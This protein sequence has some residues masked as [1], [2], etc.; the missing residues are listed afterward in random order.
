MINFV[1]GIVP[2]IIM[3][4]FS[5]M[6]AIYSKSPALILITLGVV[7]LMLYDFIDTIRTDKNNNAGSGR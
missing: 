6:L 4:V 5:G 1:T 3:I 7:G 2:M